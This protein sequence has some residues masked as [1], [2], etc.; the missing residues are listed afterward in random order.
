MKTIYEIDSVYWQPKLGA[1]GEVVEGLDEINQ[2][3]RIILTTIKG[4]VPHRPDFGS[5]CWK[6]VSSPINAAIPDLVREVYAAL[7]TWET[8]IAVVTV[9]PTITETGVNL[10]IEWT[11]AKAETVFIAEVVL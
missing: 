7:R 8:R 11:M 6:Y 4:S 9:T 3:I 2:S 5:D 10:S 1:I